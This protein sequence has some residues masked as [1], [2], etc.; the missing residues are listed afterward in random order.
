M[1]LPDTLFERIRYLPPD[2]IH[3]LARPIGLE[4][5]ALVLKL[6]LPAEVRQVCERVRALLADETSTEEQLRQAG[7][8]AAH[9]AAYAAAYAAY[10]AAHAAAHAA[11]AAD[12]HNHDTSAF[13]A[14]LM[15]LVG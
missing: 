11:D 12:H 3:V 14:R 9:A 2:R 10:A 4:G 15:L 7:D 5:M 8:A 13:I 1:P 6:E